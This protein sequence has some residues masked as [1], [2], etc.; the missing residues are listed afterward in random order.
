[1][2][3]QLTGAKAGF[4]MSNMTMKDNNGTYS[5]DFEFLPGFQIGAT[6]EFPVNDNFSVETGLSFFTKGYKYELSL[7]GEKYNTTVSMY[8]L[9]IPIVAKG[10][11]N[12]K[13][14][15]VYGILGPYLGYGLSGKVSSDSEEM[16]DEDISFGT[17]TDDD[18]K[19]LDYGLLIGA[20]MQ[21]NNFEIGLSYSLG[22]ANISIYEDDDLRVANNVISLTAGYK[23]N[24]PQK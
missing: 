9:D 15:D 7:L 1:M 8:Y 11:F 21:F 2:P 20:G 10:Y 6:A 14:F 24:K 23:F 19:P 12:I 16:G 18:F 17:S 13:G 5:N 3:P 4:N 22:L